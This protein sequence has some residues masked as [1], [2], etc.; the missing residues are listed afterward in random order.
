MAD[1]T[2][3]TENWTKVTHE[4]R[5]SLAASLRLIVFASGDFGF[6]LY[7]QSVMLFLLY[8]YTEVVHLSMTTAS[9]AYMIA[10]V[11]DG[12]FSFATGI[13]VDRWDAP[14]RY[15]RALIFGAVPLGLSFTLTY[16]PP[17][18]AG[19]M[20]IAFLLAVHM[21]FR[22][23][24]ALVN[25]PYLAMSARISTDSR[26][27]AF[28]AGV[29]MLAGTA[30]AVC[31]ALCT[32]PLGAW[33]GGNETAS[34]YVYAASVYALIATVILLIVGSQFRD[35]CLPSRGRAHVNSMRKALAGVL[36]NRA[37]MTL[38]GAMMA[39]IVAITMV[40]KAVLYYFKYSIGDP[41]AGPLA[42]ASMMAVSAVGVPT[43]M[44][45]SRRVGVRAIWL[46]AATLCIFSLGFFSVFD[47]KNPRLMQLFLIIMQLTIVGLNFAVWAMLPDTIE[48]GQRSSGVRIEGALYG[49][50]ALL[51]RVAIGMGTT[52]LGLSFNYAG[53]TGGQ[54]QSSATL[55][56]I[57]L[58]MS[59]IPILFLI[60]SAAFMLLNPLHRRTHDI[61][62]RELAD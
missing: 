44:F 47:I 54:T 32:R 43:W 1:S 30:A 39:M 11:W 27:R 42:L 31:V 56:A 15:R 62:M 22:S 50:A 13:V 37:F 17:P 38:C 19:W 21:L 60:I 7:W 51:Q 5:R 29:R 8:Y 18:F 4:D 36:S 24:Y 46:I 14:N 23:I 58:S 12:V 35:G 16:L 41:T 55:T 9:L 52:L 33:L 34:V 2:D 28:V 48:Y 40:N 61:I 3:T 6:N 57:R 10:S 26:D 20:G 59:I 49:V 25:I 53:F 45:V